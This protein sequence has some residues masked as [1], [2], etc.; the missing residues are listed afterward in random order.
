ME[1]QVNRDEGPET[2]EGRVEDEPGVVVERPPTTSNPGYVAGSPMVT[3]LAGPA[4]LCPR[5]KKSREGG[6]AY[7]CPTVISPPGIEPKQWCE[8]RV[9]VR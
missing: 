3:T 7:F 2:F 4:P 9:T 8:W 1:V 5:H 6:G